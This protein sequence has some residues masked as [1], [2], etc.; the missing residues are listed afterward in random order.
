MNPRP[1]IL[2]ETTWQTVKASAFEVVIL[3][4]GATE[5]HN[6]HLPYGTDNFQCDYVAAEAAR[7]AWEQG[8][9]IIVL[10][11][12]PFGVN[13][14]QLDITLDMNLNPSTQL[15]VLCD[16]VQVL[17]RQGIEVVGSSGPEKALTFPKSWLPLLHQPSGARMMPPLAPK[18]CAWPARAARRKRLPVL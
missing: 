1:Y 9:K 4:W 2:A 11:T 16:L 13:T 10:P 8:A 3:P 7:F 18:P 14:G 6:Y 15:A 17:A 12:I 5:A